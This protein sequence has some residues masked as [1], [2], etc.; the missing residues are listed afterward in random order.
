MP[1][2]DNKHIR[3]VMM[4]YF[5]MVFFPHGY[6]TGFFTSRPALK[7]YIRETNSLFHGA[8]QIQAV[9]GG[10]QDLTSSNP[11]YLVER[12]IATNQH[13]DAI[14]G[15]SKQHVAYDYAKKLA[16]GRINADTM[17]SSAFQ[18]LTNY[19]DADFVSCDLSNAT[20]CPILES[21]VPTV[22]TFWNQQAQGKP[23]LNVLLP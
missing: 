16:V 5:H 4:I 11:L 2:V 12:A 7:G 23:Y 3:Y 8:T 19:M 9:T 1:Q 22:I 21:G 6:L 17:L 14:T 18:K 20:I 13:H 10:A 15:S